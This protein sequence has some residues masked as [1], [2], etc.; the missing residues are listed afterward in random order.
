MYAGTTLTPASGRLLG[1]HQKIDR[2]SRSCLKQLLKDNS[3]FPSAKQILYFEGSRGPDAIKRK[4][5][6]VDEPWHYYTPFDESD[7]QIVNLLADHYRNLVRTLKNDDEVRASF[8][9][10]WIAHT[11][12]DGLTP[13]HH[14]PY[15]EKL[16]EL[17]GGEDKTSRTTYRKKI[18]MPGEN[19]RQRLSNNWQMWGPK[20]LLTS[21]IWFEWGVAVAIVPLGHR[22]LAVHQKDVDELREL[23]LAGLFERKAKEVVSLKLYDTF[24]KTGWTPQLSKKVRNQLLPIVVKTVTLAWYA[25]CVE[26]QVGGAEL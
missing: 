2:L 23:G 26:A 7:K 24:S 14:F 15:E 6:A 13:A 18:L 25:A 17:R 20:G 19:S 22:K 16:S 10:A 21:H 4:S 9:A 11:I 5:P 3:T 12:V 8:E 1:A